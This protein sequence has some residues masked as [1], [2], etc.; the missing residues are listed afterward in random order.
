MRYVV[1]PLTYLFLAVILII[2]F[3]PKINL[4]FQAEEILE[5]YKVT[6]S[7]EKLIDNGFNFKIDDGTIYFDDLVVAKVQEISI[8]PLLVYNKIDIKLNASK[9]SIKDYGCG[10]EEFEL[11]RIFDNYY[12]SDK[13]SKGF[14]IGLSIIKRFCDK[15]NISINFDSKVDIGTTVTLKF[16]KTKEED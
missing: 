8:V 6:I 2:F 9:L 16:K 1:K 15:Q 14:G 4:Y 12:Q 13:N 11:L 7:G 5:N 10:M 3:L